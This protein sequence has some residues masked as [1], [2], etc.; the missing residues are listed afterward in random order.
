MDSQPL[1]IAIAAARAG[2]KELMARRDFK[3]LGVHLI[4]VRNCEIY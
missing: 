3:M 2:A 4:A 1:E